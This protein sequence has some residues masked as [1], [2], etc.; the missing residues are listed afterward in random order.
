MLLLFVLPD[1]LAGEPHHTVYTPCCSVDLMYRVTRLIKQYVLPHKCTPN[2]LVLS[3]EFCTKIIL[4]CGKVFRIFGR[5]PI[6]H[7]NGRSVACRF[8]LATQYFSFTWH[9]LRSSEYQVLYFGTNTLG[10][11]KYGLMEIIEQRSYIWLIYEILQKYIPV[12]F[13]VKY[14]IV[15]ELQR[16]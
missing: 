14:F 5:L 1:I 15:Y 8:F 10:E 4:P 13:A 3:S 9:M 7:S 16:F 2:L 6:S 11:T 12:Y